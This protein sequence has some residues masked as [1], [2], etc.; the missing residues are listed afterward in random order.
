MADQDLNNRLFNKLTPDNWRELEGTGS[1]I[2]RVKSDGTTETL[3]EDDWASRFLEQELSQNVPED[4]RNMFEVAQGVLCYGCYFYPLYTLGSEQL[5][6]VQEAALLNKCAQMGA[7]K[8]VQRF[9]S[10]IDWMK[11]QDALSDGRYDQ[12]SATRRLRNMTS[13]ADK[14]SLL[15]QTMAL[16]GV[17]IA[18]ELINELFEDG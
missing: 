1:H 3:S 14:Q 15:D 18:V 12:W 13:H 16:S 10:A 6:R 4:I 7:P 8:K 11:E 2:V 9:V 5:Y 17:V